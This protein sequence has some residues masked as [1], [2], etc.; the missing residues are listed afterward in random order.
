MKKAFCPGRLASFSRYRHPRFRAARYARVVCL[1]GRAVVPVA[2]SHGIRRVVR[3]LVGK[4]NPNPKPAMS[5][6]A[7]PLEAAPLEPVS[8]EAVVTEGPTAVMASETVT[9]SACGQAG[10]AA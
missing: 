8:L 6:E 4:T 2:R 5:F 7:V 1:E 10:R 9:A 3:P